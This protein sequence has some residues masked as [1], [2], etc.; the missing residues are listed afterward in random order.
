MKPPPFAYVRVDTVDEAVT[1]LGQDEDA[2]LLA[3]GQSLVPMLNLRL[4][5]PS[6]LVDLSFIPTPP[7]R[8]DAAN[9]VVVVPATTT[10][11]GLLAQAGV[12]DQV[13]LLRECL[14]LIG[15]AAIRNRGTMG[16]SLAHA[17]P[18][19]ELCTAAVATG[20]KVVTR[21]ATG[22][23]VVPFGDLVE[24]PF[25]T[26]LGPDEVVIDVRWPAHPAHGV[27]FEE[28]ALRAGDFAVVGVAALV[29]VDEEGVVDE[30]AL[31]VSGLLGVPLRLDECEAALRGERPDDRLV[32]DVA[33][34]AAAAG[35]PISDVQASAAYRRALAAE[36]TRRA[37]SRALARAIRGNPS[38]HP[39][40]GRS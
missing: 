4:A 17:D 34:T 8:Y 24:G 13:P 21:A 31:A 5:R 18:A 7:A 26:G 32:R 11:A 3:G 23:R 16:G 36:L 28:V 29:H 33:A 10:H 30:S 20:A 39:P 9:D 27:A 22:Q 1:A 15:H 37:L 12:L 25:F 35:S 40:T 14:P 19:A 2:K 38:E 6:M